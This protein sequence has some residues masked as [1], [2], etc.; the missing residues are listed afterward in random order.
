MIVDDG[1]SVHDA[2]LDAALSDY[3]SEFST[4]QLQSGWLDGKRPAEGRDYAETKAGGTRV[5]SLS[6]K[7]GPSCLRRKVDMG[8][9]ASAAER[10]QFSRP[11]SGALLLSRCVPPERV[12]LG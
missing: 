6:V 10:G 12:E 1:A 5:R 11:H 9:L 8:L 3:D 4:L 7:D 2:H